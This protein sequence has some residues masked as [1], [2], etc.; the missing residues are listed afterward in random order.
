MHQWTD[1]GDDRR[2]AI[3]WARGANWWRQWEDFAAT[4]Y[5][6]SHQW[7]S[8]ISQKLYLSSYF[9]LLSNLYLWE[10]Y[11]FLSNFLPGILAFPDGF[12]IVGLESFYL[13]TDTLVLVPVQYVILYDLLGEV[14]RLFSR[15]WSTWWPNHGIQWVGFPV[16]FSFF[17]YFL[18]VGMWIVGLSLFI[19]LFIYCFCVC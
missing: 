16:C 15:G 6:D 18:W 10:V 17:V 3:T 2:T 14:A 13:Y 4:I 12:E 19:I 9:Q 8:T 11:N 1:L 5:S 7:I